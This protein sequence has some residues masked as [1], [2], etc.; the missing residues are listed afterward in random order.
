M[1]CIFLGYVAVANFY[2]ACQHRVLSTGVFLADFFCFFFLR[3]FC[4]ST[5]CIFSFLSPFLALTLFFSLSPVPLLV[6]LAV[7]ADNAFCDC[8]I[9]VPGHLA[10]CLETIRVIKAGLQC[11]KAITRQDFAPNSFAPTYLSHNTPPRFSELS[12]TATS[13]SPGAERLNT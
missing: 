6:H 3:S 10:R 7:E 13:V 8:C 9:S 5:L 4:S 12:S 2:F 11:A 1:I